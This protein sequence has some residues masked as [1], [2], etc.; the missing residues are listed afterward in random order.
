VKTASPAAVAQRF[1]FAH[2]H[3]IKSFSFPERLSVFHLHPQSGLS[4]MYVQKV[5]LAEL[6]VDR[7]PQA[8]PVFMGDT[9]M[10]AFQS[11]YGTQ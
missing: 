9:R 11:R 1:P 2:G 6:F 3:F 8:K 7:Q 5:G 10:I 4:R